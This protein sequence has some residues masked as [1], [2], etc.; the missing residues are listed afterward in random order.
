MPGFGELLGKLLKERKLSQQTL[1]QHV[2]V[3]QATVSQVILGKTRPRLAKIR[4]WADGLGLQGQ[5][6]EAFVQEAALCHAP[7]EV[8]ELVDQLRRD[9]E[10]CRKKNR[11]AE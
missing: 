5:D 2:G 4:K 7:P 11:S 9:L 10:R 3:S 6:R 8:L 1:A